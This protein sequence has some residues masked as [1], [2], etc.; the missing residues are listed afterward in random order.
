MDYSV[1]ELGLCPDLSRLTSET[2]ALIRGGGCN[3]GLGDSEVLKAVCVEMF[4]AGFDR[5]E[6]WLIVTDP[7]HGISEILLEKSAEWEDR[8]EELISQ[9]H[10]EACQRRSDDA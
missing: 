7:A 5:A 3:G 4:K 2:L 10:E 1:E 8:L 6:V 9:A